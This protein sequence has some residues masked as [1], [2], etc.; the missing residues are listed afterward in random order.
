MKQPRQLQLRGIHILFAVQRTC[1]RLQ[2]RGLVLSRV[3]QY[4]ATK[5][6]TQENTSASTSTTTT[7]QQNSTNSLL[8]RN[9]QANS[10]LRRHEIPPLFV[11]LH[12]QNAQSIANTATILHQDFVSDIIHKVQTTTSYNDTRSN[13]TINHRWQ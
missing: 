12:F 1:S 11:P 7:P 10:L 4:C 5:A 8:L 6:H 13:P 3:M 2:Y 9:Q